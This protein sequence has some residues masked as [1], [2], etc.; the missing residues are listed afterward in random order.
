M[1]RQEHQ[2]GAVAG[3]GPPVEV[4]AQ[5]G[6]LQHRGA[7]RGVALGQ[8]A[9]ADLLQ[10]PAGVGVVPD[11]AQ[12]RDTTQRRM[13]IRGTG[14]K[15]FWIFTARETRVVNAANCR[16]FKDLTKRLM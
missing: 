6:P 5:P 2:V 14:V 7:A 13:L 16:K 9:V 3:E 15:I 11:T 12:Q 1:R 4:P 10:E 8:E